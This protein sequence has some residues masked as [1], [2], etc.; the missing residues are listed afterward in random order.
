MNPPTQNEFVSFVLQ[1][2]PSQGQ[3]RQARVVEAWGGD[4][5]AGEAARV[6]AHPRFQGK[7]VDDVLAMHGMRAT[8]Q[9]ICEPG[10]YTDLIV[11]RLNVANAEHDPEGKRPGCWYRESDLPGYV[12]PAPAEPAPEDDGGS[13]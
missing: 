12:A 10:D 9:V 2:G 5:P 6:A 11:D 1:G 4:D 3:V 13:S 7:S 8:V